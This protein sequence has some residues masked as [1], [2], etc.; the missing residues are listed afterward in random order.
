LGRGASSRVVAMD[1]NWDLDIVCQQV[2]NNLSDDLRRSPWKGSENPVAGHCYVASE[3]L[4]HLIARDEGYS[5]FQMQWESSSH[6]FLM[7]GT[8]RVLD[9]TVDQFD[10]RPDYELGTKRGF[11]TSYPSKRARIL[12]DRV[13]SLN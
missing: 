8:G 13:L 6:W 2:T 7:D 1:K 5:P 9:I 11:L 12:M 3:A 4:W 10:Q